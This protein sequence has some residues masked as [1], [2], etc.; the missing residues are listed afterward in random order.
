M[1]GGADSNSQFYLEIRATSANGPGSSLIALSGDDHQWEGNYFDENLNTVDLWAAN[2]GAAVVPLRFAFALRR[3]A[4]NNTGSEERVTTRAVNLAADGVW[5]QI[6][7]SLRRESF[8]RRIDSCLFEWCA[9]L[10][11]KTWR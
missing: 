2:F 4:G 10:Q 1:A 11:R 5:R 7:F 3:P 9:F 6:E 8:C